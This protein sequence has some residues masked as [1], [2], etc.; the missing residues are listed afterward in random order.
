M[1]WRN[2]HS[3][4]VDAIATDARRNL[5]LI[6]FLHDPEWAQ[7]SAQEPGGLTMLARGAPALTGLLCGRLAERTFKYDAAGRVL[8]TRKIRQ[9]T[10]HQGPALR[11]GADS[12]L[13]GRALVALGRAAP[14]AIIYVSAV[15]VDSPTYRAL[16][17]PT[18][19]VRRAFNVL[20]WGD[21]NPHFKI[22]WDGSVANYLASLSAKRRRNMRRAYERGG[23]EL[24]RFRS[25]AEIDAFLRDAGAVSSKSWQSTQLGVGLTDDVG[26]EGL[27]R[28]AAAR[29][30][31]LGY[32]LY[33]D[34]A[35]VAYRY[36]YLYGSTLFAIS[37]AF[38]PAWSEHM[39]GSAIF[40][41]MLHDL[42]KLNLPVTSIDLLPHGN[43]FKRERA[44]VV[45][46]TRS[47]YLF[48]RSLPARTMY[49]PIAAIEAAKPL[50]KR[51]DLPPR[52]SVAKKSPTSPT[53]PTPAATP[54]S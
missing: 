13:A 32:V 12:A 22:Q 20:P 5:P 28:F 43:A 47:F 7:A 33:I 26:R 31:F 38:D 39:P 44:N 23:H 30:A 45:V 51:R 8:L 34:G 42:E 9:M 1:T 17:E 2:L 50:L 41:A 49:W 11:A 14:D 6:E 10:V 16:T 29:D 52:A 25:S 53:A 19:G 48:G 37:T 27:I 46:N 24:K 35:P 21:E 18:S 40:L 36:G 15:P 54:P 4:A 3:D